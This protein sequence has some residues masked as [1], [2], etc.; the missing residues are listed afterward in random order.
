M[1]VCPSSISCLHTADPMPPEPPAT[2]T[3]IL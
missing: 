2:R 3:F 1:A